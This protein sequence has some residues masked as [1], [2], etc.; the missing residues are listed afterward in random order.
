MAAGLERGDESER[1]SPPLCRPRPCCSA[2][3]APFGGTIGGRRSVVQI[4]LGQAL[5]REDGWLCGGGGTFMIRV[6]DLP[7][8]YDMSF[9]AGKQEGRR[10]QQPARTCNRAKRGHVK[11][12]CDWGG[13][14]GR[15]ERD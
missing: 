4:M 14:R 1:M 9:T 2:K 3:S 11:M 10:P 7:W 12:G 6:A 5:C 13:V 15:G 8:L